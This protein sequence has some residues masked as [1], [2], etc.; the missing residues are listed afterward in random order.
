MHDRASVRAWPPSGGITVIHVVP[1]LLTQNHQPEA[2]TMRKVPDAGAG[3]SPAIAPRPASIPCP[4]L[5]PRPATPPDPPL[6]PDPN[7]PPL[8]PVVPVE[9][10]VVASI[11]Y[12][13]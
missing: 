1:Q 4:P 3:A 12:V 2:W 9:V 10:E 7:D 11:Q 8:P 5:P 6:P 13:V